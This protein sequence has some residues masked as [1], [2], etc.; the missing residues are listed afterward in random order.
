MKKQYKVSVGISAYNEERTIGSV[1][2]QILNQKQKGWILLELLIYCDGCADSTAKVAKKYSLRHKE[3]KVIDD[4]INHGKIYRVNQMIKAFRGDIFLMVDADLSIETNN[5]ISYI[6]EEFNFDPNVAMVNGNVQV[7]PP[8]GFFQKAIYTSYEVH[9]KSCDIVSGGHNIRGLAGG[10]LA[11]RRDLA[12]SL[13]IPN[14]ISNDTYM[15]FSCVTKGFLFRHAKRAHVKYHLAGNLKDYLKQIFR[16]HPE[17][18]L[19]LQGKYF[20]KKLIEKE[21]SRPPLLYMKLLVQV[22]FKNP[23][24]T[25]YMTG[26]KL[27]CK[28]FFSKISG[29]YKQKWYRLE[30]TKGFKNV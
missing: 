1:I 16:T 23:I 6:I 29:N 8:K 25:L 17:A 11:L 22:F 30:S 9:Y 15:Y 19:E 7:Y 27:A 13:S 10:F 5:A 28:P 26:I 14:R 12:K 3:V 2:K 21:Y 20:D 24:G 4:P 18:I